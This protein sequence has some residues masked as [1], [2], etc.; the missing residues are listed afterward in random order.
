MEQSLSML[1]I[2]PAR[3]EDPPGSR[4]PTE[5]STA[6]FDEL[7]VRTLWTGPLRVVRAKRLITAD[8]RVAV[9]G[10]YGDSEGGRFLPPVSTLQL[11]HQAL[12]VDL[13]AAR[14]ARTVVWVSRNPPDGG[15]LGMRAVTN[16]LEVLDRLR[17]AVPPPFSVQVHR[18]PHTMLARTRGMF[19]DAAVVVGVH[20]GGLANMLFCQPRTVVIELAMPEPMYVMYR[21][22]AAAL[23]HEMYQIRLPPNTF[24]G[25]VYIDEGVMDALERAITYALQ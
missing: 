18:G 12:Q 3:A 22:L 17:A 4:L 23:G 1:G 13:P 5:A 14:P 10:D 6:V 2:V 16:E 8:W 25:P 9:G 24:H 20:G 15:P 21:Y 11:L 7:R 19:R